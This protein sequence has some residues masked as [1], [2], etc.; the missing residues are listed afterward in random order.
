MRA[1]IHVD[2]AVQRPHVLSVVRDEFARDRIDLFRD[3]HGALSAPLI[4][5]WMRSALQITDAPLAGVKRL[6]SQATRIIQR[7]SG[8]VA[9]C[10]TC[11]SLHSVL[12]IA[13]D[14]F[15]GEIGRL[16]QHLFN[17]GSRAGLQTPFDLSSLLGERRNTHER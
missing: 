13:H 11:T 15:S 17:T 4:R 12:P 8:V 5:S 9:K 2:R 6:G 7:Y 14:P 10:R 3:A 16:S 1:T